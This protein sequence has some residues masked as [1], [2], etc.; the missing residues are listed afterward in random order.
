MEGDV[1]SPPS[2]LVEC[3]ICHDEDEHLNMET[4]CSCCGSLKYAH[5]KC[6]QRWCNVKGDII[7]EICQQ[8]YRPGYMAPPP[9][10]HYEGDPLNFRGNWE[11]SGRD[12]RGPHFIVTTEHDFLEHD[13]DVYLSP[14]SQSVICCRVVAIIFTVLLVMQHAL[15]IMISETGDYSL[16]SFTLAL[17]KTIAILF[18]IC[19][20]A[21]AFT[22]AIRRRQQHQDP[23]FSQA[24]SDEENDL[25]QPRLQLPAQSRIISVHGPS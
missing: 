6:V 11:I 24:E 12:L 21:K 22:A 7:C 5:R 18:P 19:I 10:Y 2:K 13:F 15:P 14:S 1:G 8:Q 3:R 23:R 25:P 9:L 17:L 16:A 20:M 4:P